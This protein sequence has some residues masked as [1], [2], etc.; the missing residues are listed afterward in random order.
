ML[1]KNIRNMKFNSLIF[2]IYTKLFI[3]IYIYIYI[4]IKEA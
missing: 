2:K 1:H 3:Y 4:Y